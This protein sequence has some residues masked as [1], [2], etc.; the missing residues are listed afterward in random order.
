MV[1]RQ[2]HV[3]SSSRKLEDGTSS[4]FGM[5]LTFLSEGNILDL[6]TFRVVVPSVRGLRASL[7]V[8]SSESR[9]V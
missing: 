9:I 4:N 5:R 2:D 3:Y 8:Q 6:M 1:S 7:A